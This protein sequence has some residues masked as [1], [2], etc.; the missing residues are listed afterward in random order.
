MRPPLLKHNGARSSDTERTLVMRQA[1]SN[2]SIFKT[3]GNL[4]PWYT[5]N[6]SFYGLD[7]A[8]PVVPDQC[9]ITQ[10][11]SRHTLVGSGQVRETRIL[12]YLRTLLPAAPPVPTWSTLPYIGICTLC[13]RWED[14]QCY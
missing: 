12:T 9:S 14:S 10:V 1:P 8:S 3:W 11:V 5:V 6:S 4:S 2:F 7:N 13:F